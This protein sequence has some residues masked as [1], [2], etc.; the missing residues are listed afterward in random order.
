MISMDVTSDESVEQ[1]VQWILA[2][3]GRLDVVVNN[4]G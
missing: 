4:A 1:G 2:R 3:E